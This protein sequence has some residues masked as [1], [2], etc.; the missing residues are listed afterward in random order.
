[1]THL[2]TELRGKISKTQ[3]ELL[4]AWVG[5]QQAR[6]DE[7]VAIVLEGE[8]ALARRAAW[9]LNHCIDHHPRLIDPH[10]KAL[11]ENLNAPECHPAVRR[12]ITRCLETVELP[13]D[14]LGEIFDTCSGLLND[15]NEPVASRVCSMSTMCR[16]CKRHP[17]LADELTLMINESLPHGSAAFRARGR[18]VLSELA[19]LT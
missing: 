17:E 4:A 10:L 14:L 12:S 8:T 2:E 16:I 6:F 9:V 15:P 1:M 11:V 13:D 19:K 3:A 18:M 5:C 7:L